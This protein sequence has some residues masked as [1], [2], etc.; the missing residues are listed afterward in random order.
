MRPEGLLAHHRVAPRRGHDLL[1]VMWPPR[2]GLAVRS[3]HAVSF[4]QADAT[5]GTGISPV[6]SHR[7]TITQRLTCP[8]YVRRAPAHAA[9]GSRLCGRLTNLRQGAP[10][11]FPPSAQC[12]EEHVPNPSELGRGAS[13]EPR[14]GDASPRIPRCSLAAWCTTPEGDGGA[15]RKV[16]QAS[17]LCFPFP[18]GRWGQPRT[19]P[20]R[21]VS[22]DPSMQPCGVVYHSARRRRCPEESGTGVSPVFPLPT[23]KTGPAPNPAGE[24]YLPFLPSVLRTPGFHLA[25]AGKCPVWLSSSTK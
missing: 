1:G 23:R 25:Q 9:T 20:G 14:R 4:R 7:A 2:T 18:R 15:R 21:R 3:V 17:R 16:A 19:P 11:A 10:L 22:P 8:R 24:R 5:A 6:S 12:P 13:P